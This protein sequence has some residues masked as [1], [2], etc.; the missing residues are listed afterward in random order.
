MIAGN[1][2]LADCALR[3]GGTGPAGAPDPDLRGAR[4]LSD[5]ARPI[6]AEA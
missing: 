3:A 5:V 6:E 4:T 2:F 1:D